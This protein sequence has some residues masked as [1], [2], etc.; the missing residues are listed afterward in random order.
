MC[1]VTVETSQPGQAQY[2]HLRSYRGNLQNVYVY[3]S[4]VVVP[5]VS[6]KTRIMFTYLRYVWMYVYHTSVV[7]SGDSLRSYRGNIN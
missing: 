2:T 7:V 6:V 3:Y 4:F 5:V 1:I